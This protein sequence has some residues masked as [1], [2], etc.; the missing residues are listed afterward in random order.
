L[1]NLGFIRSLSE[2]TLYVKGAEGQI[3]VVSL[4]VDDLLITGSCREQIDKFKEEMKSA[5]EMIDLGGMTFF[6]GMQIF[7]KQ[8]EI[9]MCQHKYTKEILKKFNMEQCKP[10]TTPMNQKERFCKEDGAGKVDKKLYRSLIGRLMYLTTTRPDIM[11][12]VSLLSRYMHCAS[13]IYF[14]VAKRILR[15]IKGTADYG[16]KFSQVGKFNLHGY[17]DSDWAGNIDDMRSTSGYCFSF[18][19]GVFSW[20]SKKQEIVAQP[21]AEAEYVAATASANQAVW[22]RKLLA[23]LNL[24]QNE[25]TQLFVDNQAAISISNNPVFHGITKHFKIEFFF[26]REVQQEGKVK[27]LY[28]KTEEQHADILTKALPKLKFEYL[29]Q[30][31]GVCSFKAK[32]ENC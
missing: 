15:Y 26:L 21:T 11:Y 22:I 25:S 17:S 24:Q 20:S 29:R 1:Q 4:Y 18:G 12:D 27:L 6:L 9:F 7:Q 19:S 31:L 28:C 16:I 2:S 13:E 23:D 10:T 3:L 8:N 5:F 32:E 30:K 14:K